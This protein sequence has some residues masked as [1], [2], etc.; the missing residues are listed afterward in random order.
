M[1]DKDRSDKYHDATGAQ[2]DP[3]PSAEKALPASVETLYWRLVSSLPV[4]ILV[5]AKGHVV[6]ANPAAARLLGYSSEEQLVGRSVLDFVEEEDR[7]EVRLRVE[8]LLSGGRVAQGVPL[9][10]LDVRGKRVDV[11]VTCGRML[12]GEEP[13]VVSVFLNASAR[14][15]RE[16]ALRLSEE[17]FRMFFEHA[18]IGLA[19]V[20]QAYQ[21]AQVNRALCDMLGYAENELTRKTFV[22]I[23]HPEDVDRDVE[24]A[25]KLFAGEIPR[26]RL[27]KRYVKKTGEPVWI[28]LIGTVIHDV[29][30]RPLCG[31]AM[32]EDI[33]EMRR[34][35]EQRIQREQ[36]QRDALVREVHHRIK[37]NL[38]SVVGLLE[39]HIDANPVVRPVLESAIAQVYTV[40]LVHGLQSEKT[41][42][43]VLL[44]DMVAGIAAS[45]S[46]LTAHEV[47]TAIVVDVVR[48]VQV[49]KE[50]AVPLALILNEL[51]NNAIKH[52]M[53]DE[54]W[55]VRIE[56]GG[57]EHETH[58]CIRN[59]C[60]RTDRMFDLATGE[61]L[62]TGLQLVRALLP[63]SGADLSFERH[64]RE[65][66]VHLRLT[67]PV[68]VTGIR[69][70]EI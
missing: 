40:A 52:N 4:A 18:P 43:D 57:T 42:E 33:T 24:Q 55:P 10:L 63:E 51:I 48:P 29:V 37:N 12:F 26:Y 31:L 3:P 62:G 66:A 1:T 35:E 25:Q 11:D 60:A 2:T 65:V 20:D 30:G 69:R 7:K 58:L 21:L 50:A 46:K 32:I 64:G 16:E 8:T 59:K 47:D 36:Q 27:E 14:A 56:I 54:C 5:H 22:E 67:A 13:A 38:Q 53:G 17:K 49:A 15:E 41:D 28:N 44:C 9:R 23:T 19:I 45:L 34:A 70:A 39:Q 6:L 68:I 61:G